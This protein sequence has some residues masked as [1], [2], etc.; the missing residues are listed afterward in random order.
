MSGL[1]GG[2]EGEA[3]GVSLF[4]SCDIEACR[5]NGH[6]LKLTWSDKTPMKASLACLTCSEGHGKNAFVA[7][8]V[9][10]GSFGAWRRP[11]RVEQDDAHEDL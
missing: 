10:A 6:T 7:Y 2:M 9:E 8:G 1:D 5:E 3:V 11:R 4:M